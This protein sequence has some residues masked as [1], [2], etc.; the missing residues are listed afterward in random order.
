MPSKPSW[1]LKIVEIVPA[2]LGGRPK[3]ARNGDA[4]DAQRLAGKHDALNGTSFFEFL[5][6][7]LLDG[8]NFVR[9]YYKV[10]GSVRRG[11]YAGRG[12]ALIRG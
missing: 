8:V 4:I 9:L 3:L 7:K 12:T 2:Y 11:E 6:A 1:E 5:L 10:H